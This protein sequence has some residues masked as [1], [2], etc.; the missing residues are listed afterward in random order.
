[1]S[2]QN[3]NFKES[4]LKV[5]SVSF[6]SGG[7]SN[8][9][10]SNRNVSFVSRKLTEEL[11]EMAE[12]QILN[13]KSKKEDFINEVI[14][15]IIVT[16]DLF[17]IYEVS[18]QSSVEQAHEKLIEHIKVVNKNNTITIANQDYSSSF[19]HLMMYSGELSLAVQYQENETYKTLSDIN[20]DVSTIEEHTQQL[21]AK[22]LSVLL[23]ILD[24]EISFILV[25]DNY[26]K[27]TLTDMAQQMF[28]K[29]LNKWQQKAQETKDLHDH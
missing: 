21:L 5:A 9:S 7:I 16:S 3:I 22:I 28:D 26:S 10:G 27:E 19:L 20:Q 14:D 15:S 11:G 25:C 2:N 12:E 4:L 29:K 24:Y 23:N 18:A 17:Y 8:E 13:S 1:M 6:L